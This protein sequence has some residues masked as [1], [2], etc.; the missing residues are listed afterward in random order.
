MTDENTAR[1]PSV[2]HPAVAGIFYPAEPDALRA[3]VGTLLSGTA[4]RGAIPKAIIAPHAGYAYSG[5][6]AAKAYARLGDAGDRIRRVVLIGPAHRIGFYGLAVPATEYF[7][8]PLGRIPVDQD[9]VETVAALPTVFRYDEA[10]R[11]EHSL[12]VQLPF[13]QMMLNDFSIVPIVVGSA[14]AA[15]VAEVLELLWG[16]DETLIVIS[17][18]LSHYL[19]YEAAQRMDT[20]TAEAIVALCDDELHPG[21]ACGRTPVQG[22]LKAAKAHGLK[23]EM[24]EVCNSGDTAG[25][26]NQVVGYGA[27]AF[28]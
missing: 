5:P 18:D 1:I 7:E 15:E 6:V 23:G 14:T 13:L 19:D 21:Q 28:S 9:A 2:R 4:D 12:E 10:H 8:M 16:G 20:A 17:S 25:P 11:P 3:L 24:L 22:F 26:R 27:F